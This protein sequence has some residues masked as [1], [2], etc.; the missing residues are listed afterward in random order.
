MPFVEPKVCATADDSNYDRWIGRVDSLV[1]LL[2]LLLGC[3]FERMDG[4]GSAKE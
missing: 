1:F 4:E 2:E 3:V